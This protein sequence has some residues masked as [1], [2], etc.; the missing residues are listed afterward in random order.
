MQC[1]NFAA[2][3]GAGMPSIV[4]Q[5]REQQAWEQPKKSGSTG[6]IVG[7][8]AAFVAGLLLVMSWGAF[9]SLTTNGLFA[10]KQHALRFPQQTGE[11][12]HP[13][14]RPSRHGG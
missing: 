9:P 13:R 11:C 2:A 6:F 8:V 7:T 14:R 10:A 3:K 4:D 12:F 5:I 1:F